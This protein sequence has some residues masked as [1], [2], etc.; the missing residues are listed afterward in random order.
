MAISI[1]YGTLTI[2]VPQ[3]DLTP[4]GGSL[5]ELDVDA[6]RLELK[7]LEACEC[8][9]TFPDTHVH[10][11]EVTLAGVTLA[12]TVEI[13][14]GYTVEFE[15]GQYTVSCVGANHNLADVKVQNSVSLIVGN[16]AGL[17]V[18]EIG[19]S[20]LTAEEAADL[21]LLR[22]I[23]TNRFVTDPATGTLTV[24]E[25]DD[26]TVAVEADIYEDAAGTQPY[27]GSG[28]ERRDKATSP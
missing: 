24:Y 1:D 28:L 21:S 19:T 10:N 22:K 17:I 23:H 25:D 8:G 18:H 4:L 15:N 16:S 7:E 11:T 6:F 9:M 3:A 26:S 20:G 2:M 12:R 13:I 14:N 27:R 5:Y